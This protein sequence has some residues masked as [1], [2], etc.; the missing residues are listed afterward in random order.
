LK[1]LI[2]KKSSPSDASKEAQSKYSRQ[3]CP[4]KGLH[5]LGSQDMDLYPTEYSNLYTAIA[6]HLRFEIAIDCEEKING[7]LF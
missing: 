7:D 4:V 2:A 6:F 1:G 5:R 3:H